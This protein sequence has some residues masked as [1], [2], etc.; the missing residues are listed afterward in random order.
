MI[1]KVNA[2][3]LC[4]LKLATLYIVGFNKVPGLILS[5]LF[6]S[7]FKSSKSLVHDTL[8][9]LNPITKAVIFFIVDFI[10]FWF[11]N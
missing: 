2:S 6:G 1:S 10:S 9:A 4:V 7:L 3:L 5:I 8:I 11:G